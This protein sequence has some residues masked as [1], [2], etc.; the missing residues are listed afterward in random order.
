MRENAAESVA[1]VLENP[2]TRISEFTLEQKLDEMFQGYV[3]ADQ[4]DVHLEVRGQSVAE[5]AHSLIEL[6]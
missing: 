1:S 5:E 4:R 3:M 6:F 2:E